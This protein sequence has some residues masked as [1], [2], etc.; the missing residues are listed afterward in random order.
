MGGLDT[1]ASQIIT[2]L[3]TECLTQ[4]TYFIRSAPT[5]RRRD[6]ALYQGALAGTEHP[7]GGLPDH[8]LPKKIGTPFVGA[9]VTTT[10]LTGQKVR[11]IKHTIEKGTVGTLGVHPRSAAVRTL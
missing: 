9:F 2:R 4:R 5:P 1:Y 7:Y 11:N 6:N 8:T 10:I 3:P